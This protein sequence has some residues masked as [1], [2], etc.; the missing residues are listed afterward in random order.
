M[1]T[2]DHF[3]HPDSFEDVDD[4]LQMVIPDQRHDLD[5]LIGFLDARLANQN[6]TPAELAHHINQTP[7]WVISLL[8]GEIPAEQLTDD[9]VVRVAQAID[10]EPNVLRI[11]LNRE[12]VP[13]VPP[14]LPAVDMPQAEVDESLEGYRVEIERLMNA[15]TDYLIERVE[16]RYD[17]PV[18][19]ENHKSKQHDF[20][21]SQIETIFA[22]H[23]SD[24][25]SVE[26]LIDEL[27]ATVDSDDPLHE[28]LHRLDIRR[29]IH[30]IRGQ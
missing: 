5:T 4:L 10:Y 27:K 28:G 17:N 9:H 16:E 19:P 7:A 29:I 21:I 26:I 1:A 20:V 24:I 13:T 22:Q 6:W 2:L 14:T 12:I 25:H 11:M 15:I 18:S 23:R 8:R 30:H 3:E